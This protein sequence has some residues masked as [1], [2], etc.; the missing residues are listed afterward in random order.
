MKFNKWASASLV[1]GMLCFA[2]SVQA[3]LVSCGI[4]STAN[5]LS[6][7]ANA[8]DCQYLTPSDSSNVANISNINSARFFGNADWVEL[9]KTEI[10]G[11]AQSGV[12]TV[13]AANFAL[14]EY[15]IVFKAGAGTNLTA[16]L[17]SRSSND[18]GKWTS[19][20]T[21]PPFAIPG[22]SAQDVSH[23]T[24]ARRLRERDS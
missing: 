24:I 16:F 20:F 9:A 3:A 13:S 23:Y 18:S 5:L 1:V 8:V 21:N 11:D 4:S 22:G 12:W 10:S 14:Y 17:L 2:G 7:V 19:P 15:I 6:R